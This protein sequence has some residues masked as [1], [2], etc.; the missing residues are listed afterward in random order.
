MGQLE[1]RHARWRA[2]YLSRNPLEV[3][4]WRP[5]RDG[6]LFRQ[7]E[8]DRR[9]DVGDVGRD[10]DRKGARLER[11]E[12]AQ[13][14]AVGTRIKPNL[15][16]RLACSGIECVAIALLHSTPRQSHVPRPRVTFT[17]RASAEQE[18]GPTLAVAQAEHHTGGGI[19]WM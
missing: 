10:R 4:K 11:L 12:H 9:R 3:H 6:N 7:R 8:F 2:R 16:V 18:L 1:G 17:R 19:S 15:F 13:D 5:P 14:A